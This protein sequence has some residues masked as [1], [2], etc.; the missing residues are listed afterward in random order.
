MTN[1][2][3]M[4]LNIY[5][6]YSPV[7]VAMYTTSWHVKDPSHSTKSAGGRLHLNMHTPLTH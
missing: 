4:Y 5:D 6:G 7:F 2:N 3:K 1:P